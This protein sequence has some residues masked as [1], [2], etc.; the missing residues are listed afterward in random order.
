MRQ[1]RSPQEAGGKGWDTGP[2][3]L[4]ASRIRQETL[5]QKEA[6][7]RTPLR[8]KG[9]ERT[10]HKVPQP[11]RTAPERWAPKMSS[12]ENQLGLTCQRPRRLQGPEQTRV[13]L[14]LGPARSTRWAPRLCVEEAPLL[15][16]ELQPKGQ[17]SDLTYIRG[18]TGVL[19]ARGDWRPN[20]CTCC[21]PRLSRAPC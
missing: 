19:S 11:L 9:F 4:P 18:L 6:A 21:P 2:S 20:L 13:S 17:A 7:P 8:S 1:S 10:P 3:P 12:F 16:P 15:V 5:S 14:T